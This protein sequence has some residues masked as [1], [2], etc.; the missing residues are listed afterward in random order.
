MTMMMVNG[1]LFAAIIL[2]MIVCYRTSWAASADAE[3]LPPH[4]L[5]VHPRKIRVYYTGVA[6]T[7]LS[8]LVILVHIF[9]RGMLGGGSWLSLYGA[10]AAALLLCV[11]IILHVIA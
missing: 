3:R 7:G 10:I 6:L 2:L 8:L 9:G 1:L 11:G 4:L 5:A